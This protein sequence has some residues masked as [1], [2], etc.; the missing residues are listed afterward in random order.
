[1]VSRTSSGKV[2]TELLP[3]AAPDRSMWLVTGSEPGAR[4]M[5]RSMRPGNAASRTANCSATAS[6]A[7]LGSMT[8]PDP[9]RIC[10]VA[11]A[12]SASRTGGVVEATAGML[13]CSAIQ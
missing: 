9:T 5:P 6:G 13:W 12:R 10:C 7:W 1:M 11:E 8:P 4:P 3:W 2:S